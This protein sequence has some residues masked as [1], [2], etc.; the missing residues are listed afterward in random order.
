MLKAVV[1]VDPLVVPL[2]ITWLWKSHPLWMSIQLSMTCGFLDNRPLCTLLLCPLTD[3]TLVTLNPY[4]LPVPSDPDSP[5]CSAIDDSTCWS[6]ANFWRLL[7]LAVLAPAMKRP[8]RTTRST[9]G[10]HANVHH[11]PRLVG[12]VGAA[13]PPTVVA[14]AVFALFRPWF[15]F[16]NRECSSAGRSLPVVI[17]ASTS[18]TAPSHLRKPQYVLHNLPL[19]HQSKLH[20]PLPTHFNLPNLPYPLHHRHTPTPLPL[21][22]KLCS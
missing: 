8:R 9:A 19:P 15:D 13:N 12:E 18:P 10:H 17:E 6:I 14:N 16:E 1:G 5:G 22:H 3:R 7:Q 20:P 2:S 11:L 21:D 4:Q